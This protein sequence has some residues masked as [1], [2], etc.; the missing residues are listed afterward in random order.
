M[1]VEFDVR[2]LRLSSLI[3]ERMLTF[4]QVRIYIYI[5]R[6]FCVPYICEVLVPSHLQTIIAF[7]IGMSAL[8]SMAFIFLGKCQVPI[9]YAGLTPLPLPLPFPVTVGLEKKNSA[10]VRLNQGLLVDRRVY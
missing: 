8:S 5:S 9:F 2:L 7:E 1:V 3:L 10:R 4:M 6:A